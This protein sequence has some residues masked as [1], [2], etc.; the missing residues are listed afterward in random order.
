[1]PAK[2]VA[3]CLDAALPVGGTRGVAAHVADACGAAERTANDA[4]HVD[5]VGSTYKMDSM[6]SANTP[7]PII[8]I[9]TTVTPEEWLLLSKKEGLRNEGRGKRCGGK[10]C[11]EVDRRGKL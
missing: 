11:S 5:N 4:V 10:A 2:P 8:H 1:M 9:K 3:A 7:T 6:D